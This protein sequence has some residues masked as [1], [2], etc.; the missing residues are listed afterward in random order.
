[1]IK[2]KLKE[3]PYQSCL[4]SVLKF[5]LLSPSTKVSASVGKG[6]SLRRS[7]KLTGDAAVVVLIIKVEEPQ[8]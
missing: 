2:E 3:I 1:M 5:R 4:K 8:W 6:G 7:E